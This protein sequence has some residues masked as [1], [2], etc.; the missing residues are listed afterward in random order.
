MGVGG[1]VVGPGISTPSTGGGGGGSGTVTTVSVATANGFAGTVS[2]PTTTPNI[3]LQTNVNAAVLA[4]VGNQLVAAT[5]T[6]TGTSVVLS[7][8]PALT[9]APTAP[10]AAGGTNTTQIAT[11]AFVQAAL[12][13]AL[14]PS[15]AAGGDLT[16]TY[17]NPTLSGT[18][19]VESII[20][21]NTTVAGALQKTG[22]TMSGA[23]AMG[24]NKITGLANGTAST[25]AAAFGQ[26]PTALPPNGAAGGDLAGTY[27][28]PT[29]KASVGL[30]G[31][32]T[33]PTGTTGD[34]TTQIAT[35]AFVTTA[36][37]NAIAGVNPAV[38]VSA[39]TTAA[40][41]T[42]SMAYANG[43]SGIGATLTGP[44]NT[45]ITI[46]G[47]TFT[48]VGQRLLVKNDTQSPSGAF[49]GV[50]TLTALQ[51]VGTGAI[52]TR[53][54]DYDTPSDM[55]NTGAIPVVSGTANALT[56]WLLTSQV[57]TV[58]TSPLTYSEFSINPTTQVTGL[59]T[60]I[61]SMTTNLT[62]TPLKGD[63]LIIELTDNG[64]PQA[65]TWGASFESS[66]V[67]LPTTTVASALLAVAFLW[68]D[69]TTKWRCV[70]TA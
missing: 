26:I 7:A 30:T 12:P 70:A 17:P 62:G 25:D 49:N 35:D 68:N 13:T 52:F 4:S 8:S 6:G 61:T 69:V 58:G 38:A 27:P 15:G 2:S 36:V 31:T 42:S 63:R 60:A 14:P 33:A 20:T 55:N 3:T 59:A 24:A 43:A 48:A 5:T 44:V 53:A 39:A 46:D 10:T 50:Y 47:F 54:L 1:E 66:T 32:P 65:I 64:T 28:N 21:A 57:T 18:S 34:N 45:A 9:G 51:T 29:I 22:G 40:G 41:D 37:N 67:T 11:T 16:G 19:N 23:I 56:S